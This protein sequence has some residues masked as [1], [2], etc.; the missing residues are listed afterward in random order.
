M[1]YA[2]V[3]TGEIRNELPDPI[4]WPGGA[5]THHPNIMVASGA[6]WRK[7]ASV[8]PPPAGH[9]VASYRVAEIDATTCAL[10][11]AESVDIAAEHAAQAAAD[12][13]LRESPIIYERPIQARIEMPADDGHVYGLEVDPDGGDV[14]PVQRQSTR[15][16]QAEYDAAKAAR[17]A[18]RKQLRDTGKAGVSGQLQ[19]RIENIE[20][21][22]GWRV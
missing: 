10:E 12:A 14:V 17:M 2:N 13:A 15:L 6:G 5:V 22:L 3:L 9:R 4:V 11:V 19:Q 18:K 16:T 20:R 7:V 21:Y 8:Q 1:N